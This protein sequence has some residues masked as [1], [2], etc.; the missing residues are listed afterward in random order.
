[1]YQTRLSIETCHLQM[2]NQSVLQ[3]FVLLNVYR[4][5]VRAYVSQYKMPALV[6]WPQFL[7]AERVLWGGS[8]TGVSIMNAPNFIALTLHYEQN[9]TTAYNT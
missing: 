8:E 9:F 4:P 6:V 3:K 5:E 7:R 2:L 1:M